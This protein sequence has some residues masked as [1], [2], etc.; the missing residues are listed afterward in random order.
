MKIYRAHSYTSVELIRKE[1]KKIPIHIIKLLLPYQL[2][3]LPPSI[4]S[5][6]IGINAWDDKREEKKWVGWCH[7]PKNTKLPHIFIMEGFEEWGF[8]HEVGHAVDERL[9]YP[10]KNLYKPEKAL[11]EYGK[12]NLSEYFA[13]AFKEFFDTIQKEKL[14][15]ADKNIF[16]F[17]QYLTKEKI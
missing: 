13:E 9:G 12:K 17:F 7:Y 16:T 3:I 4:P 14:F 1:E 8:I 2:I 15:E 11:T 5:S 6:F 10:S